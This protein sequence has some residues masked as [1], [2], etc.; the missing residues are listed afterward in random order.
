MSGLWGSTSFVA[1]VRCR[2]TVLTSIGPSSSMPPRPCRWRAPIF[3]YRITLR[4]EFLSAQK[5]KIMLGLS[6]YCRGGVTDMRIVRRD[7]SSCCSSLRRTRT[8]SSCFDMWLVA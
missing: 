8:A 7:A 2:T 4:T 6:E 5:P 1:P 3:F